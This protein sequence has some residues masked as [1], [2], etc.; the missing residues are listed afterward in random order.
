MKRYEC[1]VCGYIYDPKDGD[2]D[3]GI[4]PGTEFSDLPEDWTCPLCGAGKE[5][6]EPLDK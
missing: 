5:S 1:L 6:F 3:A 2:P 4:E